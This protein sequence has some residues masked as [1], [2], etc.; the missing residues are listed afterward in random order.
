MDENKDIEESLEK[1]DSEQKL[2]E[3]KENPFKNP[4][5]YLGFVGNIIL[6]LLI[7]IISSG[8]NW[9]F[10]MFILSTPYLIVS[11]VVWIILNNKHGALALGILLAGSV[12]FVIT[13][14]LMGGCFLSLGYD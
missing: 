12:P 10:F 14:L 7:C 3:K 2:E 13:L 5:F 9:V 6:F 4:K 11:A 1:T 8:G